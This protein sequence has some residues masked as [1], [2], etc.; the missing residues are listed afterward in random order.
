MEL[1]VKDGEGEG[2]GSSGGGGGGGGGSSGSGS[3]GS[4]YRDEIQ[5]ADVLRAAHGVG[6]DVPQRPRRAA[7]GL[8]LF[9]AQSV[10]ALRIHS[11]VTEK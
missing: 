11:Q 4:S 8:P 10:V 6:D 5:I 9:A 3:S 1:S 7:R 2:E